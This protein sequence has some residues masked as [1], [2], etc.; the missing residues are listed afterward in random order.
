M[1]LSKTGERKAHPG[2][3][4]LNIWLIYVLVNVLY[5]KISFAALCR[6]RPFSSSPLGMSTSVKWM[7]SGG[8]WDLRLSLHALLPPLLKV[9][10][11]DG[12]LMLC[13][14]HSD[15]G[16]MLGFCRARLGQQ[17]ARNVCAH[18]HYISVY[19][20]VNAWA[21]VSLSA[22]TPEVVWDS[23]ADDAWYRLSLS[24]LQQMRNENVYSLQFI[25]RS[26]HLVVE[27]SG[28]VWGAWREAPLS[29]AQW[30]PY[31]NLNHNIDLLSFYACGGN[32]TQG[33]VCTCWQSQEYRS[34]FSDFNTPPPPIY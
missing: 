32:F 21:Y 6:Q 18:P 26:C 16:C 9:D 13:C 10:K 5:E 7:L 20:C 28:C 11:T 29:C 33:F 25:F 31:V 30:A 2:L 34:A 19:V 23:G 14:F 15:Q 24:N 17:T 8:L 4:I 27:S 3:I 1:T 22:C 12:F